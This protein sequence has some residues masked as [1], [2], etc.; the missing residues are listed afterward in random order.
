MGIGPMDDQ[1]SIAAALAECLNR[2]RTEYPNM[3][4]KYSYPVTNT[5]LANDGLALINLADEMIAYF[6]GTSGGGGSGTPVPT[7]VT[8]LPT[9]PALTSLGATLQFTAVVL[10]QNQNVLTPG[11]GGV[12][13][14]V[15][16]SSNPTAATVSSTGLG[17]ETGNG[18]TVISATCGTKGGGTTVTCSGAATL[19]P[20]TVT[21][22]PSTASLTGSGQTQQFTAVVKDQNGNPMTPGS[23][24]IPAL[25]WTSLSPSIASINPTSG[26]ATEINNGTSSIKCTC[27]SA[28]NTATLNCSGVPGGVMPG[29]NM[30]GG[31]TVVVNTGSLVSKIPPAAQVGGGV[32]SITGPTGLVLQLT[33]N[34]PSTPDGNGFWSGNLITPTITTSGF[35][36]QFQGANAANPLV[37]G[38]EP[39]RLSSNNFGSFG[40]GNIFIGFRHCFDPNWSYSKALGL[41]L[42][43]PISVAGGNNDIVNVAANSLSGQVATGSGFPNWLLQGNAVGA[44]PSGQNA[45]GLPPSFEPGPPQYGSNA[46]AANLNSAANQGRFHTLEFYLQQETTNGSS[47]DAN[48]TI[49]VDGVKVYTTVGLPLPHFNLFASTGWKGFVIGNDYGGDQPTDHPPQTEQTAYDNIL[50]AVS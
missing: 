26:L 16:A 4:P 31:M 23:G 35:G 30:P 19:V 5:A 17:T 48:C 8:V 21:I 41:K 24:G 11:V 20:T 37:G 9:L 2:L 34:A 25:A 47:G 1:G 6:A 18:Q 46:A 44:V 12:P 45:N 10:D 33:N 15:W 49:W 3:A 7:S 29:A 22:S 43:N 13:A 28:G 27:G 32:L 14:L 38:A 40:T 36:I 42:M 50:I 39:V